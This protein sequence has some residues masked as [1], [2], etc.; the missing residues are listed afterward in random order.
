MTVIRGNETVH[1]ELKSHLTPAVVPG[2]AAY[3]V[4]HAGVTALRGAPAEVLVP[5]LDGTRTPA[6]LLAAAA[7]ALSREEV[8]DALRVLDGTGLLRYRAH[9]RPAPT[10][11]GAPSG[12]G[13]NSGSGDARATEAF[14][15]LAGLDGAHA[16][17]RLAQAAVR[18]VALPG[19]DPAP[20]RAACAASGLRIADPDDREGE[21]YDRGTRPADTRTGE[22]GT[23]GEGE[24]SVVLCDDYLTPEL[25]AVD[26]RHRRAGRPWLLAR[27][28]GP[29]PWVGPVFRPGDGPCWACL[30][31]RLRGHRATELAVQRALGL[32]RPVR[33]PDAALPAGRA[34]AAQAVALEAAKWTAGLR[35]AEAG[36][37]RTLDT[38][39]LRVEAH[40]V[41][42]LPQCAA[43]GDPGTVAARGTRPFTVRSRPKAADGTGGGHRALTAEQML[44]RHGHLVG[45]VTGVVAELRRAPGAPAFTEAYVSGGNLAVR[46]TG[47]AGLRTGP[48]AL[49]GGKGLTATEARVSALCEAVERYSGSRHGDEPVVRDTYRALGADA[50]HPNAVQLFHERQFSERD[51]WNAAGSPFT[52]VP[53]PFDEERPVDWT[54]L[55]SPATG[56]RRLLPTS[57]LYFSADPP[58]PHEP[59]ADSNGCA[60]GSSPEDALLQAVLELVERDAV[61][62][63]WYHRTR[64]PAVDLDAFDEPYVERLRAGYRALGRE[65]WALDLTADLGIPVFAALS[66]STAPSAEE[67]VFGFG[68]HLDPRIALRRA[69]TEMGQ[70]LPAVA[71][72]AAGRDTGHGA[73]AHWWRSATTARCPYLTPDPHAAPRGPG[74]W[75]YTHRADLRDDLAAVTAALAARGMELLVLDQTRPDTGI[76]V[77]RAVVPG[78]RHFWPRYGP[79]RLHDVPVA[80]G[81]LAE[82]TPYER[83]NPVPLFV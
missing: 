52:A 1:V 17:E 46:P 33:R 77:V 7:P 58:R 45:P 48:R 83:L 15:D 38:R 44:R 10:A 61:A 81:R 79:G 8:A 50:L 74:A 39:T 80:L 2:E 43:C 31:A 21:P 23:E 49:S 70:L 37:L 13:G 25:A 19:T 68:A 16:T 41:P 29:E 18:I 35:G 32:D 3:L 65:V 30:A 59:V 5:L 76:P 82:P 47:P 78:L 42:R 72:V 73:A 69:L 56:A 67:I 40:P 12:S 26:A 57:M 34:L 24:L 55:W 53:E 20:V 22:A 75:A 9:P 36:R 28:V 62:L 14:F 71:A 27:P 54:P 63:W 64:Q 4:S 60:A 66:R 51:R 6:G 11:P